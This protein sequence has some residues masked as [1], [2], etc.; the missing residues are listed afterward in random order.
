MRR[1]LALAPCAAAFALL[2]PAQTPEKPISPLVGVYIDFDHVPEAVSVETMKRSVEHILKP[3]GI[4]LAWRST[5]ENH[6]TETFSDL[7]VLK[8]QGRC[9][10]EAPAP[11][12]DFGTLGETDALAYTTVSRGRILPY[13]KVQC[14]Q[15]RKAL[16]YVAPGAGALQ[17]KQALGLALGRVVAHELYHILAQS[18]SHAS[19][20]LTKTS[21]LLRDLV[22]THE[23][24]FDET[25]S[26]AIR[27]RLLA[28]RQESAGG[29]AAGA[30]LRQN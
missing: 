17:L 24:A 19:E 1:L 28:R 13:T 9:R 8:F 20:G 22:S 23:L 14:D 4:K 6:G 26:R 25:A 21:Q 18:A 7:A 3:S 11:A 5:T 29:A 15:I 10:A 2:T 12:S 30:L 27:K 16:A